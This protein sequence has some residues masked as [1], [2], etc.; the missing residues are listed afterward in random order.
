MSSS[1]Y[2]SPERIEVIGF[3]GSGSNINIQCQEV[4]DLPTGVIINGT[5]IDG[6]QLLDSLK[7]FVSKKPELFKD[8]ILTIDG[9]SIISKRLTV[10]KLNKKQYNKLVRDDFADAA[11]NFDELLCGYRLLNVGG[12]TSDAILACGTSKANVDSY[13]SIFE[14]AGI[15]LK[16]VR[17]GVE[18]LVNYVANKAQMKDKIVVI[19]LIDGFTMLS[20]MFEN[21]VNVFMSRTRLYGET[22]EEYAGQINENLSGLIQFSR[23]QNTGDIRASYYIGISSEDVNFLRAISHHGDLPIEPLDILANIKGAEN[24]KLGTH[25]AF[26]GATLPKKSIDFIQSLKELE[27]SKKPK[28]NKIYLLIPIVAIVLFTIVNA[29]YILV[30]TS[31]ANK[32]IMEITEFISSPATIA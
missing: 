20:V 17:I 25:F 24:I 22:F 12:G 32:E 18:G 27:K 28:N 8:A 6:G 3:S 31:A 16:S 13:L 14:E 21:G 4:L 2:I 5:I 30:K 9:N 7:E 26:L 15:K 10:P 29:T 11:E 19:N 1:I 23:A